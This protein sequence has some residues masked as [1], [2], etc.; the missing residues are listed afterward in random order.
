MKLCPALEE[1][2][3]NFGIDHFDVIPDINTTAKGM[4]CGYSPIGAAIVNDEIFDKIMLKG[5][6]SFVHGHTY[7]GNPLSAAVANTAMNIMKRENSFENSA[8]QGSYLMEKLQ[9]LY[10]YPFIGDIRGKGLMMGI[11]FVKNNKTKEPYSPSCNIKGKVTEYCLEQGL[12]VYPGGRI[13]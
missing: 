7:G 6:G 1:L 2:V 8:K 11:E 9:E 5:S 10:Q 12:V 4:S 13:S 3:K